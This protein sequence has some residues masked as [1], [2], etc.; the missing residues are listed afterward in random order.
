[1]TSL[2]AGQ[3]AIA[4]RRPRLA[5][6]SVA[7]TR[8]TTDVAASTS[9]SSRAAAVRVPPGVTLF[10]AASWNGI[11]IDS[12]CGGHGTCKKC[13][14]RIAA[15]ASRRPRAGHAGVLDRRARSRLAAGLPCPGRD[16]PA[17]SRC[18]RWPP[19]PRRPRSASADRS[20]CARRSQKRYLELDEPSLSDQASDL[21]RVLAAAS[22]T[23]SCGPTWPCCAPWAGCC[24]RRLQGHR[25]GRR[26][27]AD[28]RRAGR[29]HRARSFGIAFDL[30]TTTVVATLL[31]LSTGTPAG[32][33]V[34]AEQAAAVRRRRDHP[35]QRHHDGRRGARHGSASSPR[36][37]WPSWHRQ[38]ASP[39]GVEPG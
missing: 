30:G 21:E 17:R 13:K 12:T 15:T 24:A 39:A 3:S 22:T 16:R 33:A 18:R 28:R 29:H 19:G 25:G 6:R 7:A 32:G 11:A 37:R 8:P 23:S 10:D 31:D 9:S 26:R 4:T 14:V 1:M 36:S 2:R 5:T 38:F 27:R 35:D 20:S 34:D